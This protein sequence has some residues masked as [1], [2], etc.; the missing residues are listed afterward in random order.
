MGKKE[1]PVDLL[2]SPLPPASG[3]VKSADRLWLEELR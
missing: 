2:L 3:S 1:L